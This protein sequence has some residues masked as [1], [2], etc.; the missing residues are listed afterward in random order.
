MEERRIGTMKLWA[1]TLTVALSVASPTFGATTIAQ[2][3]KACGQKTQ[4]YNREGNK[5]GEAING[6]CSGYLLATIDALESKAQ[7]SHDKPPTSDYLFSVYRTY[8][9]LQKSKPAENASVVLTQA[10]RR[11]FD[12]K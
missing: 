1:P 9:T 12:C 2:L 8:A 7:C 6:F 10:Y 5:V 11:A 3:D 4:V